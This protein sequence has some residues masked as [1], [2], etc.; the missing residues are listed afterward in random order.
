MNTESTFEKRLGFVGAGLMLAMP[1][2]AM[3]YGNTPQRLIGFAIAYGVVFMATVVIAYRV[4]NGEYRSS[5]DSSD[6]SVIIGA[7]VNP[8][9]GLPMED[10]F[11]DATGAT[12]GFDSSWDD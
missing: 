1:I 5:E 6:D 11:G 10:Q 7:G 9:T 2:L 3:F 8:A 4:S 12:F